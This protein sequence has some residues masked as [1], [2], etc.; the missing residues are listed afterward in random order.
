MKV[1]L[2]PKSGMIPLRR[3]KATSKLIVEYF[4]RR[5]YP[6]KMEIDCWNFSIVVLAYQNEIISFTVALAP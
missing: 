1:R 3:A 6:V 5:L 4:S 2:K